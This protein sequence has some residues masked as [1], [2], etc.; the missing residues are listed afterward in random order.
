MFALCMSPG[1]YF[2]VSRHQ[3][4]VFKIEPSLPLTF[5]LGILSSPALERRIQRWFSNR[6][7]M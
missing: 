2:P 1:K 7:D 5:R 3:F 6:V 4:V